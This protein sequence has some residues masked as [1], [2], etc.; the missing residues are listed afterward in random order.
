M[1]D[2]TLLDSL[3]KG[4]LAQV[5]IFDR[6]TQSLNN[7]AKPLDEITRHL[8]NLAKVLGN[9]ASS[10][11]GGGVFKGVLGGDLAGSAINYALLRDVVGRSTGKP[12]SFSLI[13]P[14]TL[15]GSN[16][17]LGNWSLMSTIP[18][19][20]TFLDPRYRVRQQASKAN[21]NM[22]ADF[23]DPLSD[24]GGPFRTAGSFTGQADIYRQNAYIK[25]PPVVAGEKEGSNN[26]SS[27]L[28]NLRT[29]VTILV[30]AFAAATAAAF[31]FTKQMASNTQGLAVSGGREG[32]GT[33]LHNLAAGLGMDDA[34]LGA[35]AN[36]FGELINS[37]GMPAN[38]ATMMGI[39]AY[40]GP[41]G[42]RNFLS[43]YIKAAKNIVNDPN[44]DHAVNSSRYLGMT[45]LVNY[46]Y[47]SPDNKQDLFNHMS[48]LGS[49]DPG[50]KALAVNNQYL[51]NR[52]MSDFMDTLKELGRTVLPIITSF[53][54]GLI[55]LVDTMEK[56]SIARFI[57]HLMGASN[58]EGA[59]KSNSVS[60]TYTAALNTN[61][62][63]IHRMT[64]ALEKST[65][66][67]EGV[68]GGGD[69]T[70]SGKV[71]PKSLGAMHFNDAG[72]RSGIRLGA[73]VA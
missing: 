42:D 34:S 26:I 35:K 13:N 63:S 57:G 66:L 21:W 33:Q 14:T 60:N 64:A 39:K 5:Q 73:L 38:I 65:S 46:R 49:Q 54:R 32:Q 11:G 10:P 59:S 72:S 40:G 27:L 3:T 24:Q 53:L 48:E 4:V 67:L 29:P 58:P 23:Q 41:G 25:K 50:K 7:F 56:S 17:Q 55:S 30:A 52:S 1:D 61:T 28:M 8:V 47:L 71:I 16:S 31:A 15:A 36:A 62:L 18:S 22:L 45:D 6:L 2:S 37:G 44:Y 69:I 43:K 19:P 12:S 70:N 9:M 51:L 68:Y 20:R